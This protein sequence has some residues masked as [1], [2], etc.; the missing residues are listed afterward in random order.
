MGDK[1]GIVYVLSNPAMQ[2]LVKIGC[3]G[4][5]EARTRIDQ[6]YTTGVPAPFVCELAMTVADAPGVEADLHRHFAS[7]R[8]NASREFFEIDADEACEVLRVRGRADVTPDFIRDNRALDRTSL[9]A[10]SR[11]PRGYRPRQDFLEMGLEVGDEIEHARTGERAT[12]VNGR[13][14]RFRGRNRT[15]D[16]ATRKAENTSVRVTRKT[17]VSKGEWL[18]DIYDRTYSR[19][20]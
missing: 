11:S 5:D 10:G 4:A 12:I 13:I 16:E 1:D 2:G 18:R 17:W 7:A 9:L 20:G 8:Y 3:T 14:V 15:L 19:S 6:L